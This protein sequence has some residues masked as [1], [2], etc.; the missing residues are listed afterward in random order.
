MKK[1]SK[2][3]LGVLTGT[4]AAFAAG[5]ALTAYGTTKYVM[6]AALD[7][8]APWIV[9]KAGA[10]ISGSVKKEEYTK[11]KAEAV[12]ALSEA[13]METVEITAADGTA[14]VGHWYPCENPSRT[15]IA[16][17]GW[18]ST[19]QGDFAFLAPFW[20]EN[21]CNVLLAEQRGQN[22]SGGACMGFGVTESYD[23]LDWITWV[24]LR[25]G[26]RLPVYLGG[27][28]MGATTVLLAAGLE[29]P[30][31]VHGILADCGF[32]NP[33]AILRHVT[34]RNL[35][36]RFGLR[37]GLANIMFQKKTSRSPRDYATT[38]SLAEARVPVLLIHGTEDRF[39]PVEM[40][41][42]NYMACAGPRRLLIVP[43]AGHAMSY[44][45]DKEAYEAATR[46]FWAEFDREKVQ[47]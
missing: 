29:L 37:E 20:H 45:V 13:V 8:E 3:T 1:S 2:I 27:V 42:E 34:N 11:A 24:T 14:L 41:Y 21:G 19:W 22:N 38:R 35:H 28:S 25:A 30:E 32:T 26:R 39:V 5:A 16:M 6:K 40:T 43:G 7:R 23:C 18:R 33:T 9:E 17:H 46:R 31:N 4:A 15:I 12:L 44:Y 10:K 47:V 36:I